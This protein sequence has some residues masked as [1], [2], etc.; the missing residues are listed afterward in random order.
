MALYDKYL[1]AMFLCDINWV[2]VGAIATAAMSGLTVFNICMTRK[3]FNK[4]FDE[5][6]NQINDNVLSQLIN[7]FQYNRNELSYVDNNGVLKGLDVIKNAIVRFND[8][9]CFDE[10]GNPAYVGNFYEIN[11]DITNIKAY[12]SS[13]FHMMNYASK[14]K[15][16]EH[17][18]AWVSDIIT[19]E[20]KK[21]LTL[22]VKY[23]TNNCYN[24]WGLLKQQ[25]KVLKVD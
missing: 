8:P 7:V 20:E 12:Y 9:R 22:F 1:N 5:L 3:Q 13:L 19:D 21:W 18:M 11:K 10:N 6:T 25:L 15:N 23:G 17:Y 14:C 2:A 24:E 4:Q 16:K